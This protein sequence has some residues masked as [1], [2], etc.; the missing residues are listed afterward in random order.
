MPIIIKLR[1]DTADN[2]FK[3]NPKLALGEPGVETDTRKFKI[4]TGVDFWNDLPYMSAGGMTLEEI[5]DQTAANFFVGGSGISLN[6]ND[7]ANT[8]TIN[9][10]GLQPSG[11]Y[12]L[13]SHNHTSS[14]ITNF[15]SSVSGLLPTISNSGD[16]RVLTSTGSSVGIN[17]ESNLTFDGTNLSAPYLISSNAVGNEGGE[18][19]LAKPPSGTLSGGIII[20]S[21][22]NRLRFFEAGG[23][24]RGFYLDLS[25]GGA[26]VS[27]NLASGVGVAISNYADNRVITSDGT[28][29]GLNAESNMIFDGSILK[30]NGTGVSVS[31]HTHSLSIGNGNELTISYLT[32][33]RLDIV[34]GGDTSISYSDSSN[35]I[36]IS[37]TTSNETIDD[38]VA[39]LLTAGSGINLNYN[40]SSNTLTVNV[41]NEFIDDR[42]D[43]LLVEGTGIVLN[44]NDSNNT[45]TIN[46]SSSSVSNETIDDRV[47]ALL[48]GG[49]GINL[50]YNDSGNSLTINT[51]GVNKL[52]N[53]SSMSVSGTYSVGVNLDNTSRSLS[54]NN[55]MAIMGGDVGIGTLTPIYDLDVVGTVRSTESVSAVVKPTISTS[56]NNWNPGDGAIIRVSASNSSLNITGLVAGV[57]GQRKLLYNGGTRDVTLVNSSSSSSTNNRFLTFSGSNYI[58]NPNAAVELLYDSTSARWR[59]FG[60]VDT[61]TSTGGGGGN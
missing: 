30:V 56:Q 23:A 18:I 28:S 47:A 16:N 2:W 44:Y 24:S 58:L 8:L 9:T 57:D 37:S 25:S 51:S 42:V 43:A 48:I 4:G 13:S 31:G 10:S 11:S 3:I 1:R 59:I 54:Q 55:T 5:E 34:G 46:A 49:A 50:N 19:Q 38:R 26:N 52:G 12:A 35:K 29:T 61:P 22:Q 33:D 17:A 27:T 7:V 53:T 20:D 6:Y 32:T 15:N 60:F 36:T 45:L 39:S 41:L 40:D 21:Y 14:Q